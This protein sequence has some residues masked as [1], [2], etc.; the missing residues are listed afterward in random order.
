LNKLAGRFLGGNN[1]ANRDA[2]I[3]ANP[4]LR[5]NPNNIIVGRTYAIPAIKGAAP[6]AAA[7]APAPA[8]A[9]HVAAAKPAA[10][11]TSQQQYWY[12]VKEN[13]N[14]WRIAADQLGDGNAW[15]T[16][17]ELNRDLLKS[18][19]ALHPKMRLRLPAKPVVSAN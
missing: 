14:L 11:A 9:T 7:P 3:S 4:S 8:V 17:K 13:D 16:I 1:K 6:V 5:Q 2:I 12:T 19:D 10:P 18:G 15:T